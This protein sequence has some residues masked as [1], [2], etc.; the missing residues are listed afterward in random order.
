MGRSPFGRSP[1]SN[2]ETLF[3]SPWIR[4]IGKGEVDDPL[5]GHGAD[6]FLSLRRPTWILW[7][8]SDRVTP[9]A[10]VIVGNIYRPQGELPPHLLAA[11]D[12]VNG[13]IG[14][15]VRGSGF[16]LADIRAA[17]H[18]HEQEY[19]CLGIEPTLKGAG[20]VADLFEQAAF[21]TCTQKKLTMKREL[22]EEFVMPEIGVSHQLGS[23]ER[24]RHLAPG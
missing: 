12:E 1:S 23:A 3:R 21:G 13:F 15:C 4:R 14:R 24:R 10:T 9:R 22:P 2:P 6:T 20:V 11:L 16:R 7:P 18:G 5:A 8:A 19:L 17:L